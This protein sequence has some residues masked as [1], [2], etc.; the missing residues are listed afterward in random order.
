MGR[1]RDEVEVGVEM[2]RLGWVR[3]WMW[4]VR[5]RWDCEA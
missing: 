5:G 4:R 2:D 1:G 3:L